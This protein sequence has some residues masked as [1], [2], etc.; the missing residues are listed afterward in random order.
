MRLR[1]V[2]LV[3][4]AVTLACNRPPDRPAAGPL[5]V[6]DDAGRTVTL[7]APARRVVSLAPSSTEL[8]FALGAGD[9]VVGRTTWCKYPAEATQVP[10][11]G[12]GINPNI[13]AVVARQPDLVVLY[14]SALNATA[15]EQLQRLGIPA[16]VLAQDR[17][18][19]V[20]RD[21]R[22]LGA[23]VEREAQGDSIARALERLA[24]TAPPPATASLV[25][26]VWDNPATVIGAGSFLD[27]LARQAGARN[28]FADINSPSATVSLETIAARDPDAIVL[29]ADDTTR[30][31]DPGYASRREW[32]AI[33]A[34]RQRRFVRL[35]ADLFG[36]PTPRAT[37]A[38]QVFRQL[39]EAAAR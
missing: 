36:R 31:D 27:E 17:L 14:R 4:L 23:L 19:D 30:R 34:V 3:L 15:V 8:L 18:V 12:D 20:A 16:V 6:T 1:R 28:V 10:A 37:E 29:I 9:R 26:I 32:Q 7:A 21:A 22:L 25:F 11:V 38:V 13:E 35:P 39:L 33:R 2:P 5:T 24:A